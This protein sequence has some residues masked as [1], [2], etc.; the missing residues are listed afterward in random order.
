LGATAAQTAVVGDGLYIIGNASEENSLARNINTTRVS[1]PSNFTQIFKT[2]VGVSNTDKETELYGPSDLPYQRSKK[3]VEHAH[4]IERSFWFGEKGSDTGGTQTK[5]RRY[6]GG[7]LEHITGGNAYVQD[8]G[9]Q[10]NAPDFNTFLK[11]GFTYGS[12][13]KVLFAGG[14]I[15]QAVNE[16]CRGQLQTRPMDETYGVRVSEWASAFGDIKIVKHPDF[17]QDFSGF[18]FLIDLECYKYAFMRNR[19]TKFQTN[20]QAPDADGEIDQYISEV[21]LDRKQASRNALIKGVVD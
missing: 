19:D 9:G 2:T 7:I 11:E 18:G 20:I 5:P 1:Q 12:N 21:G 17:I 15:I 8:Q 4:D 3:A 13:K 14:G 16:I 6:T 10:L